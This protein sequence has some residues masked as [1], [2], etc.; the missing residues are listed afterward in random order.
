MLP[1]ELL[2]LATLTTLSVATSAAAAIDFD[3]G[4]YEV[5]PDTEEK[6][7]DDKDNGKWAMLEFFKIIFIKA[8]NQM[9]H[10]KLVIV[11]VITVKY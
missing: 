11:I 7:S 2:V 8:M 9:G 1:R 3:L 10:V 5:F 6:S 4:D